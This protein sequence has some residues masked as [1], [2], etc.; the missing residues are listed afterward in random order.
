MSNAFEYEEFTEDLHARRQSLVDAAP[1]VLGAVRR[2]L[3]G[4]PALHLAEMQRLLEAAMSDLGAAEAE[5]RAQNEELFAARTALEEGAT[6]LHMLFELAPVAYLVTSESS[7][8]VQA[9]VAAR[10]LL[11]VAANALVGK[12]LVCFVP[13]T[14]RAAF[15]EALSRSASAESVEDWPLLVAQRHG[16]PI[17]CRV[18]VRVLTDRP[19]RRLAWIITE[20]TH[21]TYDGL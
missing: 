12:P 11:G 21:D 10:T 15:R 18:H 13:L 17:E 14:E 16:Q 5:L 7:R 2:E 20:S 3:A 4:E 6:H 19:V 8:I 9:N 1:L